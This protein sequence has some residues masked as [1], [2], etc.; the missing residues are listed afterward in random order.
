M[1][2]LGTDFGFLETDLG[3]LKTD[4]GLWEADLGFLEVQVGVLLKFWTFFEGWIWECGH[5]EWIM[6]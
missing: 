6:G 2:F 3:F 1:I 5:Y 4:L